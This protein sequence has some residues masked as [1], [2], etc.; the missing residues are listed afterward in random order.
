[1][2]FVFIALA[3]FVR[4]IPH[5]P[6]LSGLPHLP[7]F[8]PVA[9][10]AL[11]SGFYLNRKYSFGIV[12]AAM[13][14]ADLIIGFYSPLVM[15][16]V[17]GSFLLIWL[18]GVRLKKHPGTLNLISTTLFGSIIFYLVTNFAV[19]AFPGSFMMYPKTWHGLMTCYIMGLPFF[20]SM[21][22]GDLFYVGTLFG[23]YELAKLMVAKRRGLWQVKSRI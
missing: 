9:A 13:L 8:T 10:I 22:L 18:L 17:Y 16:A 5:I 7:N 12:I 3:V 1:M 23:A 2:P 20:R 19:W 4:V 11:F 21:A 6:A 14:V 15:S